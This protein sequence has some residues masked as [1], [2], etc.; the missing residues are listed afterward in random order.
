MSVKRPILRWHG[1]KWLLAKWIIAHLPQHRVF[2]EP[3]G[4]AASVLLQKPRSYAEI[5]NDLDGEL[6]NL[7]RVAR[8]RGDE[9]HRVLRLTPFARA[10]FVSSY[11]QTDDPVE[12]A[13]RTVVRSFM[14]FGSNSH[15]QPT[16]FRAN[17][18]RSG[19][20]PA[21]DWRNY[22]DA[23]H[24]LIDRLRGVC[25]ENRDAAVVMQ[26]HDGEQTV[27]YVDPPY[28]AATRDKGG[29]YRHEMTDADHEALAEILH[30]LRGAV[31]LSGYA[32][33]LYDDL[34]RGW[35]RIER[36]SLADGARPRTEVLW[37]SPRCHVND[38]FV[39]ERA[40][41]VVEVATAI[42]DTAK[43]EVAFLHDVGGTGSGFI[44]D[45]TPEPPALPA[46]KAALTGR[47]PVT[48]TRRGPGA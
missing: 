37:L 19:T 48:I 9:L 28:V 7:F 44:P 15:N 13:R 8:D 39:A 36:A 16:G 22:P 11:A 27:H 30:R 31:V 46:P 6:V 45:G 2:V 24:A 14:G 1:G 33:R 4:G 38:L 43:V 18:N 42:T 29:D 41:A 20:T 3:F 35:H 5:Y 34:Y 40:R 23:L 26:A 10:E 32:S 21:R 47:Q 25:I 17:S 12:Q